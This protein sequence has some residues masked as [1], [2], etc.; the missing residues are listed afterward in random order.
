MSVARRLSRIV[1]VAIA[2]FVP[3]AAQG[4]WLD[5]N[6]ASPGLEG[7]L[8]GDDP[9][10]LVR[11]HL[12]PGYETE[13]DQRYPVVYLLHG[14]LG[15]ATNMGYVAN[16]V[17]ALVEAGTIEPLIIAT[18]TAF[19]KYQGSFYTNSAVTGLWD[20][21]ITKDLVDYVDSNFR[22]LPQ[23]ESRGIAGYSMGGY[24]AIKL[25]LLHPEVYGAA[26][27]VSACCVSLEEQFMVQ[28]RQHLLAAAS[29]TVFNG[30]HWLVKAQ[31]AAAAAFSPNPEA[32]PFF[33]DFPLAEDGSLRPD[34]WERWLQHDPLTL[35]ATHAS[36]LIDMRLGLDVGESDNIATGS[37]TFS[38]ALTVM[39]VDHTF[40]TYPGDHFSGIEGRVRNRVLPFMSDA[41][42]TEP[43][44]TG[45][46]PTAWAVV[47][48]V[49]ASGSSH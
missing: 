7:N 46:A 28:D 33:A 38:E 19:N 24:G 23:R 6:V 43:V 27:A 16:Q 32:E 47:K 41:L 9:A 2:F 12:P 5:A 45:V 25:A 48:R 21:F 39:G 30:A 13:P 1:I 26:Y 35:L 29:A 17:D 36:G 22:T 11:V 49:P 15:D 44:T 42:R 10:P 4:Q 3:H 34:V 40:E 37:H 8:L 20:D 14:Y 18:P 31:I